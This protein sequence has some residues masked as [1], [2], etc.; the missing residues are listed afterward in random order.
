MAL[1]TSSIVVVGIFRVT[2]VTCHL[3]ARLS[4]HLSFIDTGTL[5]G[6]RGKRT[7]SRK[8][9]GKIKA[10]SHVGGKG[11]IGK[12]KVRVTRANRRVTT[13]LSD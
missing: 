8:T 5:G 13:L 7:R 1:G 4:N 11:R 6:H 2:T 10:R 12:R 9:E 3:H